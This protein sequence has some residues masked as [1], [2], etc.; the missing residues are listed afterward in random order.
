M[1]RYSPRQ[2]CTVPLSLSLSFSFSLFLSTL[3]TPIFPHTTTGVQSN[4]PDVSSAFQ[5]CVNVHTPANV[6]SIIFKELFSFTFVRGT[7]VIFQPATS[8]ATILSPL[9]NSG[10]D[11]PLKFVRNL[12]LDAFTR[13]VLSCFYYISSM[14]D[15]GPSTTFERRAT[16]T[17]IFGAELPPIR[18]FGRFVRSSSPSAKPTE[19][20]FRW[21][22]SQL[23]PDFRDCRE[24]PDDI[25]FAHSLLALSIH[26]RETA[27]N[28]VDVKLLPRTKSFI[29]DY[30]YAYLSRQ[31]DSLSLSL[32]L[33]LSVLLLRS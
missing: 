10:L 23:D 28:S 25:F 14:F 6:G 30:T 17:T 29:S 19:E 20:T 33:S 2:P 7:M 31:S 8:V 16:T 32:S 9:D 26:Y 5:Q 24:R 4:D 1:Q 15:Q 27:R 11:P 18:I 21:F 12:L 22:V 13:R 3:Y